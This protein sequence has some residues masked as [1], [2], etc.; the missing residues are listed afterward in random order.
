M[1]FRSVMSHCCSP[2][3]RIWSRPESIPLLPF[4]AGAKHEV[5][6]NWSMVLSPCDRLGL[7]VKTTRGATSSLP[8]IMRFNCGPAIPL[9]V[10][11]TL[12][13]APLEKLVNPESCHPS[14]TIFVAAFEG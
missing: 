9:M 2:G 1:F 10:Y 8:V 7:H 13:G 6:K 3:P 5:L 11:V 12:I 14:N 4:C